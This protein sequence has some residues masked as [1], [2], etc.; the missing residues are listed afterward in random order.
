MKQSRK[1]AARAL[2]FAP[3]R[4]PQPRQLLVDVTTIVRNDLGTGIERVVRMQ[5]LELLRH[6]RSGFRVEPV[7]LSDQG[8]R[9]HYRYAQHYACKLLGIGAGN[10]QRRRD[11]TSTRAMCSMRRIMRRPRRSRRRRP[12]STPSGAHV[13]CRS[14]S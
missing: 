11:S 7:Y 3:Q 10:A 14:T 4:Y 12:A 9:R 1:Q 2:A 8:G 13:A 6:E 5:L